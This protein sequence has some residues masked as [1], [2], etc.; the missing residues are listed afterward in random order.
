MEKTIKFLW[1]IDIKKLGKSELKFGK[2]F[3]IIENPYLFFI[4]LENPS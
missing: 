3:S 2:E 4:N 1:K